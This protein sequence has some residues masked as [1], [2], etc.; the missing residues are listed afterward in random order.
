[1]KIADARSWSEDP[2]VV[3]ALATGAMALLWLGR[4]DDVERWLERAGRTL[5][6]EGE[7][8]TELIVHHAQGLLRLAQGRFD[9]ALAAF[10]AR[11]T[12]ASAAGRQAPVCA[13]DA[14][15]PAPDAG[16]HGTASRRARRA[17]GHQRSRPGDLGPALSC[18]RHLSRHRELEQAVDVLAPV[19]DGLA[20]ATHR[21]S[22]T[23]EAQVLD[24]VAREQ[25]GD[26]QAAEA[27]LERALS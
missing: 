2:V 25:L 18:R 27:S 15:P 22:A 3:T 7:P 24:A 19:I 16:P 20:P 1:V 17:R 5:H 12:D 9:E 14:G 21:S 13:A 23:T 10:R 26:Q 11:G 4:F 8:G 6:P